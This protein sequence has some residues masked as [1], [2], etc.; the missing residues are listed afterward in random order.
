MLLKER[1]TFQ[2]EVC[3]DQLFGVLVLNMFLEPPLSSASASFF[4]HE[5]TDW[6]HGCLR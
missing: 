3:V 6:L 4:D 1:A 2:L 5:A